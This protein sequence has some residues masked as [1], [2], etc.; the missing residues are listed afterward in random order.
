MSVSAD[1]TPS[2]GGEIPLVGLLHRAMKAIRDE[3]E[4]RTWQAFWLTAAQGHAAPEAAD[5]LGMT[6]AAVRKAKSRVLRRLRDELGD[7]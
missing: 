4:Q 6:P 7:P 5:R 1:E 2:S 3:F